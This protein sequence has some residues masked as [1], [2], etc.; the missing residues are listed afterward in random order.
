MGNDDMLQLSDRLK[1]KLD[2]ILSGFRE[3]LQEHLLQEFSEVE[4]EALLVEVEFT[5]DAI[6][7]L[8]SVPDNKGEERKLLLKLSSC[9][10]VGDDFICK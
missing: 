2:D 6:K 10:W 7:L 3:V 9:H 1:P 4:R 5:L 8:P